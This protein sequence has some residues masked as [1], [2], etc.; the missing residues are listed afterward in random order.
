MFYI[1]IEDDVLCGT[2]PEVHLKIS[3]GVATLKPI[4]G[5]YKI[6]DGDVKDIS[7]FFL[8]LSSPSVLCYI[9]GSW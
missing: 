7:E 2:S 6:G 5:T 8:D 4:A 9:I 3:N 1:K